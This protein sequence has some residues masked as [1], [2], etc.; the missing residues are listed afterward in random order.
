MARIHLIGAFEG[1]HNVVALLEKLSNVV[2]GW[3][4]RKSWRDSISPPKLW[5]DRCKPPTD[6]PVAQVPY[7]LG[8]SSRDIHLA[9]G[10]VDVDS[11]VQSSR[12]VDGAAER[13]AREDIVPQVIDQTVAQFRTRCRVSLSQ[14]LLLGPYL[15]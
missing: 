15:T 9:R 13:L 4:Y 6:T 1:F 10:W 12:P 5:E 11:P 2:L 3:W 7:M 8:K 14:G